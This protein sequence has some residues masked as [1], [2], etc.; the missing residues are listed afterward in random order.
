[1]NSN[2]FFLILVHIISLSFPALANSNKYIFYLNN[3]I[4]NKKNYELNIQFHN[5]YFVQTLKQTNLIECLVICSHTPNCFTI[6]YSN[7]QS[8]NFYSNLPNFQ[9]DVYLSNTTKIYVTSSS[10]LFKKY[11]NFFEDLK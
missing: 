11:R 10:N 4:Q 6:S 7:M 9:L 1:M 5:A 8:C 3:N 2:N